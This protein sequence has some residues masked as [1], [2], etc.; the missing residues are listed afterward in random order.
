LFLFKGFSLK[1]G[2]AGSQ[3][4]PFEKGRLGGI[5]N[6]FFFYFIK[7]GSIPALVDCK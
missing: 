3:T 6:L 7:I 2:Q 1:R 4:P 5:K